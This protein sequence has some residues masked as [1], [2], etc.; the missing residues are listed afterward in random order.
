MKFEIDSKRVANTHLKLM[1][2]TCMYQFKMYYVQA[3]ACIMLRF[4]HVLCVDFSTS[5]V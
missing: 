5:Y 1:K 3:L 2:M 4:Y